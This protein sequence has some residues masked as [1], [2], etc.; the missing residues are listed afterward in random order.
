MIRRG[1]WSFNSDGQELD[2]Q[3]GAIEELRT[4]AQQGPVMLLYAAHNVDCNHA[5][6]LKAYASQNIRRS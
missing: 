6:A 5:V 3:S 1:G 4:Y 2:Q